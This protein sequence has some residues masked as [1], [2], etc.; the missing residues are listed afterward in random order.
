MAQQT[1]YDSR[2]KLL[3]V[4]DAGV[5]KTCL[6]SRFQLDSFTKTSTP[7][8]GID[9]SKKDIEIDG[10]TV[11]LQIWDTSGHERFRTITT[12]YYG[13]TNGI[14]VVYDVS[15]E[16]SFLNVR[17]WMSN[18]EQHALNA[19]FSNGV[20]KILVGH[21]A[22]SGNRIISYK[23]GK[24]L[25]HEYQLPFI[26][27]SAKTGYNVNQ[28]FLCLA[29]HVYGRTTEPKPSNKRQKSHF[30]KN[31]RDKVRGRNDSK[32]NGSKA[33]TKPTKPSK[34]QSSSAARASRTNSGFCPI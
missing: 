10:T 2:I 18:I 7:T 21:K 20:Q 25:A 4:G 27:V 22:D 13:Q 17:N 6:L 12:S 31:L 16:T 9:F 33:S 24:D 32:A 3:M 30:L 29:K 11:R 14:M 8:L 15:N 5:G 23:R 1:A 34:N 26:E 28:A 19:G